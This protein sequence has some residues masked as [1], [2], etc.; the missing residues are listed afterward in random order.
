MPSYIFTKERAH[1]M[2]RAKKKYDKPTQ[3]DSSRNI[4][5][6]E[7]C[8]ALVIEYAKLKL[9]AL[10]LQRVERGMEKVLFA[11]ENGLTMADSCVSVG[12]SPMQG[13]IWMEQNE[14]FK[15]C[16]GMISELRVK[17]LED[18]LLSYNAKDSD[19]LRIFAMSHND[20]KY[21]DNAKLSSGNVMMLKLTVN[22]KD[23]DLSANYEVSQDAIGDG[24]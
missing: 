1:T 13:Y 24:E 8:K 20:D 2:P 9:P 10:H 3:D 15:A 18:S 6:P 17:M 22:G 7:R 16:V 11:M 12:V 14:L 19:L 21:N 23:V 5:I 4:E